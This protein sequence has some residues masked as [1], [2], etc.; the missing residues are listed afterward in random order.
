MDGL[1]I[2]VDETD[3]QDDV[4]QNYRRD[5][6]KSGKP[7]FKASY[8]FLK[9]ISFFYLFCCYSLEFGMGNQI[10]RCF[11]QDVINVLISMVL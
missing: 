9:V 6:D 7:N 2:C 11:M 5:F 1:V 3:L 8:I 4:I 10:Q